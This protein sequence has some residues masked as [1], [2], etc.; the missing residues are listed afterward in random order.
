MSLP[1]R[2][3][4]S[5]CSLS[6]PAGENEALLAEAVQDDIL[7]ALAKIADLRVISRTSV[8]NYSAGQAA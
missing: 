1:L 3:K 5:P 2:R 8:R 4:V 6:N 7:N